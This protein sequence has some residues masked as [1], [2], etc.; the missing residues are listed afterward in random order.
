MRRHPQPSLPHF[1]MLRVELGV[2]VGEENVNK[3]KGN[4]VG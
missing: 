1:Q 2:D 4:G 3:M